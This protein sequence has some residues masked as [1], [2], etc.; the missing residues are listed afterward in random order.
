MGI[1]TVSAVLGAAL[2][3]GLTYLG[4]DYTAVLVVTISL[5]G[6]R[7]FMRMGERLGYRSW[8]SANILGAVLW[9]LAVFLSGKDGLV[10][11]F[12][13]WLLLV[14]GRF[15]LTYPKMQLPEALYNFLAV[16][17]TAGLMSHFFLLREL[18]GPWGIR[19][20][21]VTF[22][23]VWATDTGAYLIGKGFGRHLL[24]PAV[25]PSKTVEG[26]VG[27]L[28]FS[29]GVGW[30]LGHWLV[31]V[32]TGFLLGLALVVGVSAQIGDLFESALKRAAGVKDSGQIIP[33]HGGILDRFDSFV[34]VL[35]LVYYLVSYLQ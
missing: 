15:A 26:S 16:A 3:L 13:L 2:L 12:V 35:P 22:F 19:W 30:L 10:L 27:G 29:L 17:Y 8:Q 28:F 6:L 9:L 5:L 4:G 7:E 34:F 1:R 18:P 31:G 21:F 32:P 25:S 20:T 11:G 23:L 14:G 24:A 33:G